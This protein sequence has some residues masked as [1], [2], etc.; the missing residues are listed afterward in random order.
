MSKIT[1][2]LLPLIGLAAV[3]IAILAYILSSYD[4]QDYKRLLIKAV[5]N[6]STYKL[7]I[8]GKFELQPSLIP[9]LSASAIKLQSK[10][11]ASYIHIDNFR[12]QLTLAALL[13][14]TLLINDLQ[15]ENLRAVI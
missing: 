4:N 1:S 12:I 15:V 8:N 10:V 11:D 6:F 13:D 5:D 7:D 2:I 14:N 3:L 9:I